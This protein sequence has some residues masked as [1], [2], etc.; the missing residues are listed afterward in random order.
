VLF[1]RFP[2]QLPHPWAWGNLKREQLPP[3]R[4]GFVS[5]SAED[6]PQRFRQ[7]QRFRH[8]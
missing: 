7:H 5:G 1:R 6:N 2:R 4:V 3:Q 8:P